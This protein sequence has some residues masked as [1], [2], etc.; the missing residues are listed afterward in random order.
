MAEA[1]LIIFFSARKAE[2][3]SHPRSHLIG[4][5]AGWATVRE[6]TDPGRWTRLQPAAPGPWHNPPLVPRMHAGSGGRAR[7]LGTAM[8]HR[9]AGFS[10]SQG[11]KGS[12]GHPRSDLLQSPSNPMGVTQSSQ[13]LRGQPGWAALPCLP[14]D[15]RCGLDMLLNPY[16]PKPQKAPPLLPTLPNS[17]PPSRHWNKGGRV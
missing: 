17:L 13:R 14:E 3:G 6:G 9:Q 15:Q 11:M 8:S 1:G 12:S 10:Q 7:H 4:H 5:R 16:F 2:Q